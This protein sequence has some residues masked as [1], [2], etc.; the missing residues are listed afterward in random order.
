MSYFKDRVIWAFLIDFNACFLTLP[1]QFFNC[2]TRIRRVKFVYAVESYS[3]KIP[4]LV[5]LVKW[6]H[7]KLKIVL[8][9]TSIVLVSCSH[10]LQ[11]PTSA[12]NFDTV[13]PVGSKDLGLRPCSSNSPDGETCRVRLADLRPTQFCVGYRDVQRKR[14]MIEATRQSKEPTRRNFFAK[15]GLA[16]KGP[17]DI[18]YLVDGH[19]RARALIDSGE[20]DFPVKII[21]DYSNLTMADFWPRMIDNKMVWLFDASGRGPH[22]PLNLPTALSELSDDPYRTLAEDAQERGA[23][24]K[25]DLLFREFYWADFYR[26]RIDPKLIETDY[27]KAISEALELAKTPAANSLPGYEGP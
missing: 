27:E 20:Q 11:D 17:E 10:A 22:S 7:V 2:C 5:N 18:F 6:H 8:S 3:T 4:L 1:T 26:T 9:L 23:N 12:V 21:A 19:H 25:V 13:A 24:K 14:Q 16:V 15:P